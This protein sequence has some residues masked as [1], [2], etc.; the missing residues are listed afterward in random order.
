MPRPFWLCPLLHVSSAH[1]LPSR[2]SDISPF[3]ST[4]CLQPHLSA[5]P[6]CNKHTSRFGLKGQ[7]QQ[8]CACSLPLTP[9]FRESTRSTS[10]PGGRLPLLPPPS[11]HS[12]TTTPMPEQR[13]QPRKDRRLQAGCSHC[14]LCKEKL[15]LQSSAH[16]SVPVTQQKPSESQAP[17]GSD[18]VRPRARGLALLCGLT[19]ALKRLDSMEN[20][21]GYKV[22]EA[23]WLH[24]QEVISI[25]EAP[26]LKCRFQ[27]RVQGLQRSGRFFQMV[28]RLLLPILMLKI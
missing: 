5:A 16:V 17:E 27:I 28:S 4:F 3:S 7:L 15:E 6:S 18:G 20:S 10:R 11:S 24:S 25:N 19:S 22:R 14:L 26:V 21:A 12:F 1:G 23:I 8:I 13:L 9:K 2:S